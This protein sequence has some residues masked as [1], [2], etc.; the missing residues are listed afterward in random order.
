MPQAR[1]PA[2]P[3]LEATCRALAVT[4][5]WE[6][7]EKIL[8]LEQE[9][10]KLKEKVAKEAGINMD[11]RQKCHRMS[12][13]L[14]NVQ[15]A[16]RRFIDSVDTLFF[17]LLRT[18][19]A[20]NMTR[21]DMEQVIEFARAQFRQDQNSLNQE[22]AEIFLRSGVIELGPLP[23][24]GRRRSITPSAASSYLYSSDEYEESAESVNSEDLTQHL[25]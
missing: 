13:D 5:S 25:P 23:G 3:R 16:S 9:V 10:E 12:I 24:P 7:T 1:R 14:M 18:V 11:L 19:T 20:E 17:A 6:Y 8:K 4:V 22:M 2:P 15:R 21:E